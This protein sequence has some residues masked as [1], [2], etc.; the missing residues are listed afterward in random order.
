MSAGTDTI[1]NATQELE[2]IEQQ[3]IVQQDA[4]KAMLKR[5]KDL[6][7]DLAIYMTQHRIATVPMGMKGIISLEVKEVEQRPTAEEKKQR[8]IQFL[9]GEEK[10]K[11]YTEFVNRSKGKITNY[12][13]KYSETSLHK[14]MRKDEQIAAQSRGA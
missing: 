2:A 9:G 11:Q 13:S 5:R 14:K 4:M 7:R 6:K 3:I 1:D 8:S 10:H 12:T